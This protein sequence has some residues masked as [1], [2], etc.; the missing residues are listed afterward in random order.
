MPELK[1]VLDASGKKLRMGKSCINFT[2]AD[3]LP[4]D[5]IGEI[6]RRS[7]LTSYVAAVKAARR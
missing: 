3:Q 4:L 2:R 7:D 5:A 1:A 6:I